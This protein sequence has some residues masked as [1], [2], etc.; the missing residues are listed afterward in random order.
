LSHQRVFIF[1]DHIDTDRIIPGKYTKTLDRKVLARHVFEDVD[2]DF[3]QTVQPGDLVAAGHNFGCGSSREQAALAIK[4]AGVAVVIARSFARIFFRNAINIGLP[5]MEVR[6]HTIAADSLLEY[7]LS[8]GLLR[9]HRQG[10]EY[11]TQPIP[12][13]LEAII[14]A[15]GL[16]PYLRA[17]GGY[18]DSRHQV[19]L[20]T[21]AHGPK[22]SSGPT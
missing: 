7:D 2:P 6:D 15:G 21:T 5:L 11:T 14:A 3:G 12:P 20:K 18:A 1:G 19:G 13:F 4:E 16:V 22:D 9:D 10:K 8:R 17:N